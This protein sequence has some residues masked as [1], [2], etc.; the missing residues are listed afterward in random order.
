MLRLSPLALQPQMGPTTV[1][2]SAAAALLVCCMRATCPTHF[3]VTD[4]I[5]IIRAEECKLW[6]STSC[7]TSQPPVT[8]FVFFFSLALQPQFGS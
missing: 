6:D 2:A 5:A 1:P 7:D 3:I 8:A 4:L